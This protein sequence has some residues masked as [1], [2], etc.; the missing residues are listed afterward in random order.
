[1]T[2]RESLDRIRDAARETIAVLREVPALAAKAAE[3]MKELKGASLDTEDSQT[4]ISQSLKEN[5]MDVT[6]LTDAVAKLNAATSRV[7]A[8]VKDVG[9]GVKTIGADIATLA[10]QISDSAG[11]DPAV[12]AAANAITARAT[13][14]D[15]SATSLDGFAKQLDVMGKNP[16]NPVPTPPPVSPS[17]DNSGQGL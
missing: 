2:I 5:I 10:Q 13:E 7:A 16:T 14:L 1:M 12:I 6:I 3:S 11:A 9:V 4:R 15:A 8:E 17:G